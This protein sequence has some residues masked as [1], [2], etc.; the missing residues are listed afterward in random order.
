[1]LIHLSKFEF[2]FKRK[3]IIAVQNIE[4]KNSIRTKGNNLCSHSCYACS[5]SCTFFQPFQISVFQNLQFF[6]SHCI[7]F[8]FFFSIRL[9]CIPLFQTSP[10]CQQ[11]IVRQLT[12]MYFVV[13]FSWRF[14]QSFSGISCSSQQHVPHPLLRWSLH[15]HFPLQQ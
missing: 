3:Q 12:Q 13:G 5:D 14:T 10:C 7:L 8:Q 2:H 11:R 1:M 9:F 6:T 15:L 4:N